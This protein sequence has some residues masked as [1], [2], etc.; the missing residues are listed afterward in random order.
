[1]GRLEVDCNIA[2][3]PLYLCPRDNY[4]QK[5]V[6]VFFGLITSVKYVCSS[7]EIFVG[8]TPLKPTAVPAG[9]YTLLIPLDYVWEKEGPVELTILP[10]EKTYFLLKVFSSRANRPESDHGG[11]GGGGGGGSR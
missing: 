6:K 4:V 2:G 10:D 11:G 7:E 9:R 5:E 8:E 1:M 3:F